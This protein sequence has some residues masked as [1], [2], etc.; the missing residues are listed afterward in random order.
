M[1]LAGLKGV[2]SQEIER[3]H[4]LKDAGINGCT[5]LVRKGR[6]PLV[7]LLIALLR[8]SGILPAWRLNHDYTSISPDPPHMPQVLESVQKIIPETAASLIHRWLA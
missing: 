2:Q 6:N 7:H 5:E 3:H 8:R 4:R 1:P